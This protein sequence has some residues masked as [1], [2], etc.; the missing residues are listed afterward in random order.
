M[1][2]HIWMIIDRGMEVYTT[3]NHLTYDDNGVLVEGEQYYCQG[4]N[5]WRDTLPKREWVT[6]LQRYESGLE[7]VE[8][9]PLFKLISPCKAKRLLRGLS[10]RDTDE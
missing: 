2:K 10:R 4:T 1:S 5:F 3:Y 7:W 9:S 6:G 8:K